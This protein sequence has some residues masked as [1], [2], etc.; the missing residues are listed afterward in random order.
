MTPDIG[1][2]IPIADT[3][4]LSLLADIK[5]PHQLSK[6]RGVVT[7]LAYVQTIDA[8]MTEDLQAG[9]KVE[10]QAVWKHL[11]ELEQMGYITASKGEAKK[12]RIDSKVNC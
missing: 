2:T 9:T 4:L 7:Y 12:I 1:A 3:S 5:T 10:L 8:I 6:Q 11:W